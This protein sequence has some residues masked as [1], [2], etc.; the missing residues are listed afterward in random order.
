MVKVKLSFEKI[1]DFVYF[2]RRVSSLKIQSGF[3]NS[4]TLP[5][6]EIDFWFGLSPKIDEIELMEIGITYEF[7]P[8]TVTELK[9]IPIEIVN[10][11]INNLQADTFFIVDRTVEDR[12][13]PKNLGDIICQGKDAEK[14][15]VD[16]I[17]NL[18]KFSLKTGWVT[19]YGET[20]FIK[21]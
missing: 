15:I 5:K 2:L 16:N 8:I 19:D 6:E 9:S 20:I 17:Q 10:Y 4:Q 3:E 1:T 18:N 12:R 14:W 21:K 13:N 7:L 11:A